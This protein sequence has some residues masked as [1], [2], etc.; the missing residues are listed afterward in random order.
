MVRSFPPLAKRL[1]FALENLTH[2]TT[3][4]WRSSYIVTRSI[5]LSL[6]DERQT[7][8]SFD[9]VIILLRS[10]IYYRIKNKEQEKRRRRDKQSTIK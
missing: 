9:P 6:R 1:L 7:E 4:L 3:E 2:L 5:L 10:S 8:L